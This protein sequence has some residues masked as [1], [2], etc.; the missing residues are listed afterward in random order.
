MNNDIYK[1]ELARKVTRHLG[2]KKNVL[3]V[4]LTSQLL[5]QKSKCLAINDGAR[6]LYIYIEKDQLFAL[7]NSDGEQNLEALSSLELDILS[8]EEEPWN[9]DG[10]ISECS[11]DTDDIFDEFANLYCQKSKSVLKSKAACYINKDGIVESCSPEIPIPEKR[12]LSYFQNFS[13]IFDVDSSKALKFKFKLTEKVFK[14]VKVSVESDRYL[15]ETRM[16]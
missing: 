4:I 12:I 9:N 11:L 6:H 8:F 15:I 14:E 7:K 3:E 16:A 10:N 13:R 1:H 5:T 2:E